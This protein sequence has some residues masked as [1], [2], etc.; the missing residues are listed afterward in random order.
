MVVAG[1]SYQGGPYSGRP[2][3]GWGQN[4]WV[5]SLALLAGC[6]TG[7]SQAGQHHSSTLALSACGVQSLCDAAEYMHSCALQL[8]TPLPVG[9]SHCWLCASSP[10]SC[11]PPRRTPVVAVCRRR[12][13]FGRRMLAQRSLLAADKSQ[14]AD[15]QQA[16]DQ[17]GGGSRRPPSGYGP[18]GGSGGSS[19]GGNQQSQSNS[20]GGNSG[21][22]AWQNA[23]W[24]GR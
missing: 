20:W 7:S 14:A 23:A 18:F 15:K 1:G 12:S 21:S 17:R 8:R 16:A 2:Y 5:L 19:W 22:S 24:G 3:G 4:R 11:L 10:A 13:W 9:Q 6:V